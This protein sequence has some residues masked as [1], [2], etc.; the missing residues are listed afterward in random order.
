[1]T[2]PEWAA[3]TRIV[4]ILADEEGRFGVIA[5]AELAPVICEGDH[6]QVSNTDSFISHLL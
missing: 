2:S 5:G 1:M 4:R 3:M 6:L